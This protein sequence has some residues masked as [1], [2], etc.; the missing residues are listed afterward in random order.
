MALWVQE[1]SATVPARPSR[2]GPQD[3]TSRCGQQA[4]SRQ[5][6]GAAVSVKVPQPRGHEVSIPAHPACSTSRSAP[7]K[8]LAA[9]ATLCKSPSVRARGES[10]GSGQPGP[11]LLSAP[12]SLA[13]FTLLPA[14]QWRAHAGCR[15]TSRLCSR[16]AAGQAPRRGRAPSGA[17]LRRP[18]AASPSDTAAPAAASPRSGLWAPRCEGPAGRGSPL[19][20]APEP[21]CSTLSGKAALAA[22]GHA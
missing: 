11:L 12:S 14:P 6:H 17:G 7:R 9:A 4:S 5:G 18:L 15:R 22:C 16:P 20:Q 8:R 13:G 21:L 1:I 19:P 3:P 2:R 10:R